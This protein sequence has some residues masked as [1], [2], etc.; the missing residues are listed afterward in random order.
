MFERLIV[1]KSGYRNNN[2]VNKPNDSI[3][4][5]AISHT[6]EKLI[7]ITQDGSHKRVDLNLQ[8][9]EYVKETQSPFIFRSCLYQVMDVVRWF[10]FSSAAN[11]RVHSS[12]SLKDSSFSSAA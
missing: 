9:S 10:Q 5:K 6:I 12:S 11:E 8:I 4:P 2:F 1:G 3:I 7:D